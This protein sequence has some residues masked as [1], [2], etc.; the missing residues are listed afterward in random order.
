[1]HEF[2][3]TLMRR[4][5]AEAKLTLRELALKVGCAPSFLSEVEHGLRAAPKD[6][7]TLDKIA[8]ALALEKKRVYDSAKNDQERRDLKIFKEMFAR[9][10]DLAACYCR[11]KEQC[12]QDELRR[13]FME[14][15]KKASTDTKRGR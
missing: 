15:F 13:L 12:D 7:G 8:E 10:D 14:V 11:A 6:V 2:L 5:R 3:G 9:D 4:Y 1:M